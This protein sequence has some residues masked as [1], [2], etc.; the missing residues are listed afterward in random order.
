MKNWFYHNKFIKKIYFVP[1]LC[2]GILL[3]FLLFLC[4]YLSGRHWDAM[5]HTIRIF[6][7][8]AFAESTLCYYA[9][10]RQRQY[11][12]VKDG[13]RLKKEN[14][15]VEH[16]FS[17]EPINKKTLLL[18][19]KCGYKESFEYDEN[20]CTYTVYHK[21]HAVRTDGFHTNVSNMYNI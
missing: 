5:G 19:K 2:I 16:L 12:E 21:E 17:S 11:D 1:Y 6:V 20:Y 9:I 4:D 14:I 13:I 18:L 10:I 8:I 3:Y 15:A 7:T